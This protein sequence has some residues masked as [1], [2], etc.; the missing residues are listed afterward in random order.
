MQSV[1]IIGVG[2]VGGALALALPEDQYEI[3]NLVTRNTEKAERISSEVA[4]KPNVLKESDFQKLEEDIIFVTTQDAEIK[5]V[6]RKLAE[7]KPHKETFVFHTSGSLPSSVMKMLADAG[8][9][10]GSIHPLVSISDAQIGAK[11]FCDAFFCVEGDD[12]ATQIAN[13]IVENLGG[14][15]FSIE[16]KSKALYHASAVTACGHLVALLDTAFRMFSKC[17]VDE[18]QSKEILMPLI[19]STLRN[20]EEQTS[21]DA[22]TGTFDRVDTETFE[23]HLESMKPKLS[24]DDI[25][26]Y[27]R[28]G[29]QSLNLVEGDASNAERLG[30]MKRKL[31]AEEKL[32]RGE[33]D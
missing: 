27:L 28:L 25:S 7:F 30:E 22:L 20:L 15:S 29:V 24:S 18:D 33:G 23:R 10:I 21:T 6:A 16:T 3:V 1:S 11:R 5:D 9:Y 8:Y 4:S 19:K 31:L 14:K 12:K 13:E 17:G 26:V 2:R 32:L